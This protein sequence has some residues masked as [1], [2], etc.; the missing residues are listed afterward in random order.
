MAKRWAVVIAAVLLVG[1][2]PPPRERVIVLGE[3]EPV[4]V[5]GVATRLRVDPGAAG[6]LLVT[7]AIANAATLKGGGMFGFNVG[8]VVGTVGVLCRTAV[9]R[10]ALTGVPAKRRVGWTERPYASGV[11]ATV[12]PTG[13]DAP[14]ISFRGRAPAPGERT[15]ALDLALEGGLF[16]SFFGAYGRMEVAGRPLLIRLAPY[17][18]HTTATASAARLLADALGGRLSGAATRE[19][20]AFGIERPVRLMTLARPLDVG[21][22]SLSTLRVRVPDT[23]SVAGIA[24]A[25]DAPARAADPDEVVVVAKDKR[26]RRPDTLTLGADVL[27]RCSSMVFD[28]P[29][30]QVRLTCG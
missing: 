30:R 9:A 3:T 27:G 25:T 23:G 16:S 7:P 6:L 13:L 10:V 28:K 11:D 21:P 2:A 8:Y 18:P 17:Q 19:V 26:K 14:V 12:G 15:A 20:I 29:A 22:L 5:N 24:E 1:A 4:A